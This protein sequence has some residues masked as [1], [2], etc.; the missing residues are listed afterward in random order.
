M[1]IPWFRVSSAAS[2]RDRLQIRRA[3]REIRF[4][5]FRTRLHHAF[6]LLG[7]FVFLAEIEQRER[8][9]VAGLRERLVGLQGLA[10]D[11]DRPS[12]ILQ[13]PLRLAE[14][15]QKLRV[16]GQLRECGLSLLAR[17]LGPA[18][19]QIE[20]GQV[21]A[22]RSVLGID[23]QRL[24]QLR[25]GVTHHLSGSAHAIRHAEKKVRFGDVGIEGEDRL[26]LADGVPGGVRPGEEIGAD[27]GQPLFDRS[28][29]G[30]LR[31]G[32]HRRR[33]S[34]GCGQAESEERAALHNGSPG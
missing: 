14:H 26:Q 24:A 7:G 33:N 2:I 1:L 27:A 23:R 34:N 9:I 20:L 22:R 6:E 17:A 3:E 32:E 10:K 19:L 15:G 28:L 12:R 8:Q 25:H 31:S 21:E 29:I 13:S 5:R 30:L 11:L 4:R 16:A 18:Q